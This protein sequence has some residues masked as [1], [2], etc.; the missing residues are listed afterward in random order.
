MKLFRFCYLLGTWFSKVNCG[1]AVGIVCLKFSK[2]MRT[3]GQLGLHNNVIV[4]VDIMEHY[5]GF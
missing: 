4:G 3:I 2:N 1:A 5:T